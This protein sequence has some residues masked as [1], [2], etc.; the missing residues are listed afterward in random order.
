[1]VPHSGPTTATTTARWSGAAN[2]ARRQQVVSGSRRPVAVGAY[3]AGSSEPKHR[4]RNTNAN[5][6]NSLADRGARPTGK[7]AW[8]HSASILRCRPC[9]RVRRINT[10]GVLRSE[11]ITSTTVSGGKLLI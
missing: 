6:E 10:A 2:F 4:M 5:P 9:H 8:P 1:M 3:V 7:R 11:N